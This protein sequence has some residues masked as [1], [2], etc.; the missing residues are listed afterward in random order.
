MIG[1]NVLIWRS[2]PH[3]FFTV[4]PNFIEHTRAFGRTL[5]CLAVAAVVW[6]P[7]VHFLFRPPPTE[8]PQLNGPISPWA[9]QLAARHLALWTKPELKA[10]ELDRM[11]RS[12]AEWD[13]MGRTFLALSLCEMSMREPASKAQWLP[14]VDA[15]IAETLRLERDHG[16]YFFLMPYA[17]ARPFVQQP[18]RSLFLDSE[19]ALM[20]AAR[21]L[22]AE[23]PEL[24]RELTNRV[25]HIVER[26]GRS[27]HRVAES[28]PDECWTFDHVMALAALRCTD[29]LTGSDHAAFCHDWLAMAKRD[30]IHQPSGLLISSFTTETVPLDG[31]EGSTVWLA[32]HCLRLL[33]PAFAHDQFA[34]A[35]RELG[36]ELCGFSWSREWPRSWR[37]PADIDS[38]AVI[39][40]LDVSAGGS[41]LAF[42]AA[43]S[44]GYEAMFRSLHTTLNFAA[45]P[46]RK[47]G[48]LRYCA[49]NQVGDAALL[50]AAV[51]GPLWDKV[52]GKLR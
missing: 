27:P 1:T 31:P 42:V 51:L 13:F 30:L 9:R 23:Q 50:Y 37:S 46:A 10:T 48:Q 6:L 26:I 22:V 33:D 52:E 44:F 18:V 16:C 19:I 49:S 34:R 39:P 12:N 47:D 2:A 32:A 14:V 7:S 25:G 40:G 21:G 28:Y 43:A 15:I 3:T 5:A 24:R 17:Q 29:A 20:L 38:G 36:R 41:G 8:Q 4:N 35:K 45:F 11:R